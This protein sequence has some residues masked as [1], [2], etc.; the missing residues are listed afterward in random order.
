[1]RIY[2]FFK[3]KEKSRKIIDKIMSRLK[4]KELCIE[5]WLLADPKSKMTVEIYGVL[6]FAKCIV[7]LS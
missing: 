1:M 6:N 7:K 3:Y 5:Y 2:Q 4:R